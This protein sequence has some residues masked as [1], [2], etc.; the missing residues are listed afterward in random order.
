MYQCQL[1]LDIKM[2]KLKWRRYIK[3]RAHM[4]SSR[5]LHHCFIYR[6][7]WWEGGRGGR[8][9]KETNYVNF[10]KKYFQF[11]KFFMKLKKFIPRRKQTEQRELL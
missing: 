6:D 5:A 11:M 10:I 1:V 8:K 9:G 7:I 3:V 2:Q 4:T